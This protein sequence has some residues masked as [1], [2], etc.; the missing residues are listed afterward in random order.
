[1]IEQIISSSNNSIIKHI[2]SLNIKKNREKYNQ[3]IIDGLRIVKH[4]IENNEN[5]ECI[6]ITKEFK[7]SDNY[8]ELS[9]K[10]YK[11]YIVD[12]K[13][14]KILAETENPQGIIAIINKKEKT[15]DDLGDILILDRIQDPGNM[16]TLIRTADAA[17]F[18]TVIIVKGSTDP[19]SQKS[20]RSTMGSIMVLNILYSDDIVSDIME[21][22]KKGYIVYSSALDNGINFRK[23]NFN[24]SKIL[25]VGNE[26][27]GISKSLLNISN[28]KIY[29]PMTGAVESLNASIAGA[30][31]MFEMNK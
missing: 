27:N 20:L 3:Y 7:K 12:T 8:K 5:I 1:M 30:I 4:A 11:K 26:A 31:L 21:L 28:K 2:K 15:L 25:I 22:K 29:I 10:Q 18:S 23:I 9:L 16:G 6:I 24:K 13:I 17:G 19:F 14:M